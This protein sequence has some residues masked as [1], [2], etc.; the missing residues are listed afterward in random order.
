MKIRTELDKFA[1]V[2]SFLY[3]IKL[4]QTS[5]KTCTITYSF[6]H[7]TAK[8]MHDTTDRAKL[9]KFGSWWLWKSKGTTM[10]MIVRATFLKNFSWTLWYAAIYRFYRPLANDGRMICINISADGLCILINSQSGNTSHFKKKIDT[11][12]HNHILNIKLHNDKFNPWNC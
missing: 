12:F 5:Y 2:N 6:Y 3:R 11:Y 1:F 10:Q 7:L 9:H 8:L 4:H